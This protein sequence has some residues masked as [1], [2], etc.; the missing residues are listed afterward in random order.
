MDNFEGYTG[1]IRLKEELLVNDWIF[2]LV[3]L[4]FISFALMFRSHFRLFVKMVK[5]TF[6]LKRRASLFEMSMGRAGNEWLYRS[7]MTFQALFLSSLVL[8]T[9]AR[10]EGYLPVRDVPDML[11]PIG[12]ILVVL[13]LF[14]F[15]KHGLYLL[16]GWVFADDERR[17]LWWT[18]Y[19]AATGLWGITLYVPVIWLGFLNT[20]PALPLILY[21][22]LY[23]QYRFT[24]LNKVIRIFSI[25]RDGFLFLSLYLCAEEIIPLFF[26]FEGTVCLY[27]F[28]EMSTLW[29]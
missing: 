7:F 11:I 23:V 1:I 27:N 22:F 4:L 14:Y 15:L 6:Q 21:A 20:P 13:L 9:A 19:H 29:H 24:L 28:I 17:K 5:D 8:F 2:A 26:L 3:L 10:K 16:V 12:I 25:K 18:S